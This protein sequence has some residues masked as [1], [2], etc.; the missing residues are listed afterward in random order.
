MFTYCTNNPVN[1]HDP[2][3]LCKN[4]FSFYFKVDCGQKNCPQSKNYIRKTAKVAVI[5]D[6][7]QS[8]ILNG[9]LLGKGFSH[10]GNELVN[11][12]ESNYTVESYSF[13]S[14]QEFVDSWN[15][16]DGEYNKVYIVAHGNAGGLHCDDSS[17]GPE[18]AGYSYS[19]QSLNPINVTS[20]QLYC[21]DGAS[22]NAQ[23][24]SVALILHGLTGAPVTAVQNGGV[25]FS[26]DNCYPE[27]TDGGNW[28]TVPTQ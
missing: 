18:Y 22:L 3:G 15:G 6:G 24:D 17:I 12:L 21:C 11:R 27:A 20:I 10:Q 16:L 4:T 9:K 8:G 19:F 28:I 2:T 23:G 1:F 7:R 26:W 5:Y 25:N 14:M 13:K